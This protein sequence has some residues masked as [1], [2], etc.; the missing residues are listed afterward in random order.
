MKLGKNSKLW[1][2]EKS[3][4][5]DCTIGED[6]IIHAMV[7]IG[8]NVSIGDRCKVQAFSFIPEGVTIGNDVFIGPSVTFTNDLYP[9]SDNWLPTRVDDEASIGA[10]AVILPGIVIGA[11]ARVGAG[12]V[13]TKDVPPHAVVYGNPARVHELV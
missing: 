12:S 4:L 5:L 10:G 3:L 7:W 8:N 2:P 9:P 11:G 13:V 1:H 6:C